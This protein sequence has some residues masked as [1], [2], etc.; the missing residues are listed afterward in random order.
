MRIAI[1]IEKNSRFIRLLD[2]KSFMDRFYTNSEVNYIEENG[3]TAAAG[4]F[5]AKEA[6]AKAL[7]CGIFYLDRKCISVEHDSHGRPYLEL[8]G[9][10]VGIKSDISISHAEDYSTAVCLLESGYD[11]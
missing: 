2:K 6:F 7:G 1:D 10:Y 9:K 8:S 4:I 3:Y 11:I 5:C